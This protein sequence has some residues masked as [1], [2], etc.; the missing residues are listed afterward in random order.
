MR[1]LEEYDN[2][3]FSSDK[4]S[5]RVAN[6]RQRLHFF[7]TSQRSCFI[8]FMHTSFLERLLH[9]APYAVYE[10][11]LFFRGHGTVDS[12]HTVLRHPPIQILSTVSI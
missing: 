5:G 8:L 9:F 2:L 10:Y 12:W 3:F 6:E 4:T 11:R 1:A 7:M